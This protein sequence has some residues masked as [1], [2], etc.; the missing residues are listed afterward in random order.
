MPETLSFRDFV[1]YYQESRLGQ[2]NFPNGKT[3]RLFWLYSKNS[4]SVRL[5]DL[6]RLVDV[7][8]ARYG[9][10]SE[11][12]IAVI[13]PG[14]AV[15]F[16]GYRETYCTRKKFIFIGSWTVKYEVVPIQPNDIDFL[17]ITDKNMEYAG[18]WLKKGGFHLIN[19]GIEQMSQCIQVNDLVSMHTLREGVPIFFDERFLV[20]STKI[21]IMSKTPR[22]I[23]WN[24]DE[25]GSLVGTIQ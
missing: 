4:L 21:G 19:R 15:L 20:L 5:N 24:E 17:V 12:V 23:S 13:A 6:Y 3:K 16:P 25:H 7:M 11:N 10:T 1:H 8:V 9:L 22:K 14:S 2:L 18:A